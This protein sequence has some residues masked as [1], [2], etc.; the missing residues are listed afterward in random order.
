LYFQLMFSASLSAAQAGMAMK[1]FAV[2]L[3]EQ[4]QAGLPVSEA[5]RVVI[6]IP[7]PN[8]PDPQCVASKL[9]GIANPTVEDIQRAV[10]QCMAST[11]A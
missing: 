1:N 8:A 6:P 7:T 5:Y 10:A 9:A 11:A 4:L 2:L 3:H